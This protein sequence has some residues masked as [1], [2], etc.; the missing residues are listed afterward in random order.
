MPSACYCHDMSALQVKNLP[1]DLH[2]ELVSRASAENLTISQ[3]VT[4][5]LVREL[6]RPSLDAWIEAVRRRA[7]T[8]Q[9]IDSVAAVDAGRA[10]LEDH[11][12]PVAAPPDRHG[13]KSAAR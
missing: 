13:A 9:E 8:P 3:F 5:M 6:A 2:A 12:G 7:A 1:D 4:R 11:I 10:E